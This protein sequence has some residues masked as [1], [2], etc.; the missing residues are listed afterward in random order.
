[1]KRQVMQPFRAPRSRTLKKGSVEQESDSEARLGKASPTRQS[2][3][4]QGKQDKEVHVVPYLKGY[5]ESQETAQYGEVLRWSSDSEGET[6]AQ[7]D[8]TDSE[9]PTES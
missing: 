1:M 2:P 9:E 6:A 5:R 7:N 4:H 3:R 8:T